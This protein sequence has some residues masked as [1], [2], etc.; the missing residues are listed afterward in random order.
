MTACMANTCAPSGARIVLVRPY[1]PGRQPF[2]L[3][4]QKLDPATFA[5]AEFVAISPGMHTATRIAA[6]A[7]P[8][9]RALAP[10]PAS[11]LVEP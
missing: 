11:P 6:A 8:K 3:A 2:N 1:A 5:H 10:A 7:R 9:I 4:R